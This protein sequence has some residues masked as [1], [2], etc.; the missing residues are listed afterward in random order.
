MDTSAAARALRAIPSEK[1]AQAS[2]E[3][4]RN[5]SDKGVLGGR[6]VKPLAN[7][8]CSCGAVDVRAHKSTCL[9]GQ[10]VKRRL[11]RGLPLE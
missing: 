3:N 1:R 2:R 9:R 11:A 7:I 4:G 6:P 8:P 5:A 10:A